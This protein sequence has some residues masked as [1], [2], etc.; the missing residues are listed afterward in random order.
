[1]DVDGLAKAQRTLQRYA[2]VLAL[3]NSPDVLPR[4]VAAI[5]TALMSSVAGFVGSVSLAL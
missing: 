5:F 1:L 3:S 2:N 4:T